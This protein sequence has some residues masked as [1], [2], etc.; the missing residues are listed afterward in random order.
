MFDNSC[1]GGSRGG[2][3]EPDGPDGSD[4]ADEPEP[5]HVEQ[6]WPDGTEKGYRGQKPG[7][8][9]APHTLF[10]IDGL[11]GQIRVASADLD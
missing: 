9:F 8:F 7:W 2:F 6:E 4:G 5:E 3:D 11:T 1:S 10:H